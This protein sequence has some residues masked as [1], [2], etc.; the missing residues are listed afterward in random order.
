[1]KKLKM[2]IKNKKT[3]TMIEFDCNECN[4]IKSIAVKKSMEV[5]VTR[6]IKG[7]VL[8]FSNLSIKSFAYNFFKKTIDDCKSLKF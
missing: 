2:L 8:I 5:G 7:K 6:F 4:S 3:E 1:M